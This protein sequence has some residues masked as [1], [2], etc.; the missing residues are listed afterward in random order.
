MMAPILRAIGPGNFIKLA[1]QH[2]KNRFNT[3]LEHVLIYISEMRDFERNAIYLAIK[4]HIAIEEGP[5]QIEGK[6]AN[7]R[8][9]YKDQNFVFSTNHGNAIGIDEEDR[10]VMVEK[11][12]VKPKPDAYYVS[13]WNSI[14]AGLDAITMGWL[15]DR[16]I[17]KFNRFAPAPMTAAKMEMI[18]AVMSPARRWLREQFSEGGPFHGRTLLTIAEIADANEWGIES[19]HHGHV[20][21]ALTQYG[22]FAIEG[23]HRIGGSLPTRVWTNDVRLASLSGEFLAAAVLKDRK[24]A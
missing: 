22:Y 4:P 2:L 15:L 8:G 18:D 14:N 9:G 23:K 5:P 10:R 12:T 21:A 3:W 11:M 6:N 16:D 13:L 24:K 7:L 19:M 1:P 20:M 17:S